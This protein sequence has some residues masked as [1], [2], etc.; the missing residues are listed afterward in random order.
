M[1]QKLHQIV[2][3]RRLENMI[4]YEIYL[5]ELRLVGKIVF[6]NSSGKLLRLNCMYVII[7]GTFAW[8]CRIILVFITSVESERAN[9]I[10]KTVLYRLKY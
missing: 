5:T 8:A 2:V 4:A 1:I 10:K 9:K 7:I 3:N 6:A